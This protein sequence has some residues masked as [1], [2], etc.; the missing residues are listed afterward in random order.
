M[1][2]RRTTSLRVVGID[3][4]RCCALL[5][6]MA[7]HTLP[8]DHALS[9]AASGRASAL[10]AVLAGVSL[11]L[12]T[13]GRERHR[14]QRLLADAAGLAVRALAIAA[15]GLWLGDDTF[16]DTD[17]A[18]ILAYY[19][20]LFL[21][22]LPFLAAGPRALMALAAVWCLCAPAIS[23]LLRGTISP[24]GRFVPAAADLD[25]VPR[26]LTDLL[27]TGYYP[28]FTWLTYLLVGMALGRLD[29]RSRRVAVGAATGGLVIAVLARTSSAVL[30]STEAATRALT[31][32][33]FGGPGGPVESVR[34]Q[35]YYGTTP[36]DT[37]WWLTISAPH[38]GTPLDLAHTTGT[39]LLVL[40]VALVVTTTASRLWAVAFGAG[41]MTL[42][43][44]SAHILMLSPRA[45]P[46]E[47]GPTDDGTALGYLGTQ[48]VV[49]LAVGAGFA[50]A[51][52]RGPLEWVVSQLS[53]LGV[54]AVGPRSPA[55][56]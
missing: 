5:G 9:E 2:P 7:T 31:T 25:D 56:R 35:S 43:L 39:A 1:S 41:A 53:G 12:T 29:L 51:G 3:V 4:A 20:V 11:A 54:R 47:P 23:H 18:V 38:S 14:G 50:L 27:L 42:T 24:A 33:A 45:W 40:G 32:S 28:A 48:V 49:V 46:A 16:F 10:F 55:R 19:G 8:G 22:G 36:T 6:M 17:V 21:L 52:L 30:T 37:W 15:I 34:E 26:L 44:Y 13:G